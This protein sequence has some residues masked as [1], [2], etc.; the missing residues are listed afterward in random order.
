MNKQISI[1]VVVIALVGAGAFL[2]YDRFTGISENEPITLA[3]D[4]WPPFAHTYV[5]EEKGFFEDEGLNVKLVLNA[6]SPENIEAFRNGEIDGLFT[7][8]SDV[9]LLR[10]QGVPLQ[11]V[12]LQDIS[13]GGDVLVSKLEIKSITDLKEKTVGVDNLNDLFHIFLIE[14]LEINGIH[15]SD[16]TIVSADNADVPDALNDGT[17]DAG[18]TWEPSLSIALADGNRILSTSADNA[19]I[20]T[21]LLIFQ[22]KFVEERPDDVRKIV[23]SLF[24]AVEYTIQNERESYAIMSEAF[25]MS[26]GSLRATN[27][28]NIIPNLEESKE[29]FTNLESKYS[30]HKNIKLISDFYLEKG[31]IDEPINL[32]EIIATEIITGIDEISLKE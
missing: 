22:T 27:E 16:V 21:D 25:Q 29:I 32:D 19:G 5:A 9:L 24:K 30:L 14:L 18:F 1:I 20:I 13:N 8:T 12:Y 2:S 26:A 23:K 17:I 15:E 6:N 28:G 4:M 3:L 31:I 10:S 11:I 7:F